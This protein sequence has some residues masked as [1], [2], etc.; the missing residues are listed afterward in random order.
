VEWRG[1]DVDRLRE[2]S[3]LLEHL[4]LHEAAHLVLPEPS[5]EDNC[6]RWAF[7][8]LAGRMR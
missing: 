1:F 4:V 5:D 3:A 6:D 7:D 8:S 2:P